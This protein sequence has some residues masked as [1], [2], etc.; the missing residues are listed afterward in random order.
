MFNTRRCESAQISRTSTSWLE[1]PVVRET[2][3]TWQRCSRRCRDKRAKLFGPLY[4][5]CETDENDRHV[6]ITKLTNL[7]FEKI[8]QSHHARS[9]GL[10]GA[11]NV[12]SFCEMTTLTRTKRIADVSL[13]GNGS[14]NLV[15]TDQI[16]PQ[17]Q[18]WWFVS[19]IINGL[20]S[21]DAT[22]NDVVSIF[23]A[24][25]LA[26]VKRAIILR[27]LRHRYVLSISAYRRK[28]FITNIT[29]QDSDVSAPWTPR[30]SYEKHLST[31][32]AMSTLCFR[33]TLL[34]E[35][36]IC[37]VRTELRRYLPI[38]FEVE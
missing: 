36:F 1:V 12:G 11:N 4:N 35:G 13:A 2:L 23:L 19:L 21:R 10:S 28:Q 14:S 22:V 5:L 24:Y 17:W 9:Y 26:A 32:S 8:S 33:R 29:L 27:N 34:N 15:M 38:S 18:T 31:L 6:K 37:F 7:N 16:A 20:P 25:C 30:P 3:K